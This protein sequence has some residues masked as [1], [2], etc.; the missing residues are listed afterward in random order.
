MEQSSHLFIFLFSNFICHSLLIVLG[1]ELYITKKKIV[2][3]IN[4]PRL[5]FNHIFF[6]KITQMLRLPAHFLRFTEIVLYF[7][8]LHFLRNF[9]S[10]ITQMHRL[11]AKFLRFIE[12]VIL[13]IEL[14]ET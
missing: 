2:A 5:Y 1:D 11:L 10:K 13:N 9:F 12:I 7:S 8:R 14:I 6:R 4:F 3:Y